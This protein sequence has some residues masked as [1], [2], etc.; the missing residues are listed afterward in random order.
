MQY[1]AHTYTLLW[2]FNINHPVCKSVKVFKINIELTCIQKFLN[3]S[4]N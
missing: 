1:I 4:L 2:N 3:L